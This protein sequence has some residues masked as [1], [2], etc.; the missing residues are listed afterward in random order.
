LA[1]RVPHDGPRADAVV[2]VELQQADLDGH[3][4]GL[5]DG[6]L[7]EPRLALGFAQL[8]QQRPARQ[9]MEQRID[10]LQRVAE[11]RLPP[12]PTSTPSSS[13]NPETQWN[14]ASTSSSPGRKTGSPRIHC[15]PMPT[16]CPPWPENTNASFGFFFR[17]TNACSVAGPAIPSANLR[18]LSATSFG[19][20]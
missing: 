6:G 15:P 16:H 11:D 2:L 1:D 13:D 19:D 10:V 14:S 3:D 5:D 17:A 4:R 18:S 8:L 9:L 20:W 7:V 12:P